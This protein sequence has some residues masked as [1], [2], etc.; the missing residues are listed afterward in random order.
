V[1]ANWLDPDRL[2]VRL[3]LVGLMFASLL[4]SVAVDDAFDHPRG[5]S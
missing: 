3:A 4:T 5:C 1:G 2:P